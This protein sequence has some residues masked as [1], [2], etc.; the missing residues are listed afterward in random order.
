M[1]QV[2]ES[3]TPKA[4]ISVAGRPFE[5]NID[6]VV[7]RLH[8]GSGVVLFC[9]VLIVTDRDIVVTIP[10][11]EAIPERGA[12]VK[13]S[14]FLIEDDSYVAQR[15]GVVHWE[16]GLHGHRLAGIFL[17]KS[18]PKDLLD[19]TEDDRRREVRYPANLACRMLDKTTPFNGR[20]VNYSLNG[21]ATQLSEP[22]TIGK[23][24]KVQVD[25]GDETVELMATCRWSI[26]TAYGFVNG[27]SLQA[28]EGEKLA[29]REFRGTVMPWDLNRTRSQSGRFNLRPDSDEAGADS[30]QE[31]IEKPLL[32]RSSILLLSGVLIALSVKTPENLTQLSFLGGCVGVLTYVG[33]E[34]TGRVRESLRA[35]RA[36][37][38]KQASAELRLKAH[39][40]SGAALVRPNPANDSN[41]VEQE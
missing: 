28:G 31:P 29:K 39:V 6:G 35:R 5:P 26:E 18:A 23:T 33:L 2:A 20:L 11:S 27:C 12:S 17:T 3:S 30:S 32:S 36:K 34:W 37:L 21:L 4:P 7:A 14:L 40:Q 24:Y 10:K 15:E 1:S 38:A 8:L 13:C 9:D 25:A 16:M 22:L 19:L 41:E